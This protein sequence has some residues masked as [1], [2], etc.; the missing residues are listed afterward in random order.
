MNVVYAGLDTGSRSCYCWLRDPEGNT[1]D[2]ERI[3]STDSTIKQYFASREEEIHLHLEASTFAGHIRYLI[4][5]IVERVV[6]SDPRQNSLV[7]ENPNKADQ[8]DAEALAQLLQTGVFNEVWYPDQIQRWVFRQRVLHYDMLDRAMVAMKNRT[9]ARF[10]MNGVFR[11]GDLFDSERRDELL[12]RVS[13]PEI[14]QVLEQLFEVTDQLQSHKQRAHQ[15]MW[16][17][18][19]QFPEIELFVEVPGVGP[20]VACRFSAY[21]GDPHRF[22]SNK[23]VRSYSKLGI[24]QPVSDERPLGYEQLDNSGRGALKDASYMAFL[25]ATK[26]DNAISRR[27]KDSIR[28]TGDKTHARLNTQRKIIDCLWSLWRKNEPYDPERF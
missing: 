13:Y 10:L 17:Y 18:A 3:P 15:N 26:S 27:Y 11:R 19:Q 9:H 12:E 25:G 23:E 22:S 16:E 2:R 7:S 14:P 20:V 1:V 5:P 28:E 24:S 8:Q 6:V 4:E 21:I